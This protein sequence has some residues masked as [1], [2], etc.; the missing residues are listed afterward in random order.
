[1][2]L[3]ANE[4]DVLILVV[5][6]MGFWRDQSGLRV[7]NHWVLILVVMDMGFWPDQVPM[8]QREVHVL[9]LVVMDMGFW[10]QGS[11]APKSDS[12]KS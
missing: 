2:A 5:M 10:Q 12:K 7:T 3:A 4:L 1:M 8:Y 11:Q 6:D 9:I